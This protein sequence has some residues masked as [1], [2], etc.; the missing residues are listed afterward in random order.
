MAPVLVRLAL[1]TL[2]LAM[3]ELALGPIF[4]GGSLADW[5]LLA[6]A[7]AVLVAGTAGFMGPLLAGGRNDRRSLE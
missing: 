3:V 1:I 7:T 2:G 5:A 6:V 4:A